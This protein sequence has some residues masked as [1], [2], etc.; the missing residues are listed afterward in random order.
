MSGSPS[1]RPRELER[2]VAAAADRL[3]Q[4]RRTPM[5]VPLRTE[6][7]QD[8]TTK[9]FAL[10]GTSEDGRGGFRTCDL[11]RVKPDQEVG[12]QPPEQGRL[13]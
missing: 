3:A 5:R 8:P 2:T 4:A 7:Q 11:S 9:T 13:F 1:T 12:E 6:A 10:P